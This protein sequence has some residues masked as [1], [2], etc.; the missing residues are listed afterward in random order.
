[1]GAYA[2]RRLLMV[3]P[4]LF[5]VTIVLFSLVRLLPGDA[6][7]QI[8]GEYPGYASEKQSLKKEK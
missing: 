1:M 2:L 5:G 7:S 6:V 4:T 8:L 3:V